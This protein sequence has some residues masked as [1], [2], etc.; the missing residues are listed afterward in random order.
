[1]DA[2][3]LLTRPNGIILQTKDEA[4]QK[5]DL[6]ILHKIAEKWPGE[7]Y[8]MSRELA[9]SSPDTVVYL[10]YDKANFKV[11]QEKLGQADKVE[12][13][14]F[15]ENG[16]LTNVN[17]SGTGVPLTWHTYGWLHLGVHNDMILVLKAPC[18]D[19]KGE[20]PSIHASILPM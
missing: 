12:T 8:R 6:D 10:L 1:M 11:V 20:L 2:L 16:G 13:K 3:K 17:Q 15:F 19:Y 9:T 14:Y 18:A 7:L 4:M 5:Q